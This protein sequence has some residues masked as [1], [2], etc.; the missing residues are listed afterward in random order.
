[1]SLIIDGVTYDI[2]VISCKREVS[3]LDRYAERSE[4]GTL[5][6][7]LIGVFTKYALTLAS[8]LNTP[9]YAAL[10]SVLTAP[11]EWHTVT[12]PDETGDNALTFTAYFGS[13]SDELIKVKSGATYWKGCTVH[14]IAQSPQRTPA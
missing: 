8:S 11:T 6:R 5:H 3:F 9:Q 1:M 7:E 10:W 12:V 2:G 13:V 14:F 4:D